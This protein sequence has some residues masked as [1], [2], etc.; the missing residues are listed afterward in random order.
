MSTA[1]FIP[2]RTWDAVWVDYLRGGKGATFT[3]LADVHGVHRTTIARYAKAHG[4][5]K[6]RR[7]YRAREGLRQEEEGLAFSRLVAIEIAR[8]VIELCR[9]PRATLATLALEMREAN[10]GLW[11][12]A[13]H[14]SGL[15]RARE[16][17]RMTEAGERDTW[18]ADAGLPPR[19]PRYERPTRWPE[20]EA[21]IH[22]Y[23]GGRRADA[24]RAFKAGKLRIL[25]PPTTD[26][27]RAA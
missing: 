11:G 5:E 13:A 1:T 26:A 2:A 22:G 16:V 4:W 3:A 19:D 23:K 9:D 17:L 6:A 10:S 25:R 21:L 15:A 8:H 14:A 7:L 18:K 27:R 20:Y 24:V 12:V